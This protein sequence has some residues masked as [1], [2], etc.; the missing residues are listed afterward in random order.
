MG[1]ARSS[2]TYIAVFPNTYH[3]HKIVVKQLLK[4]T[5]LHL[6]NGR[7]CVSN[8]TINDISMKHHS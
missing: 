5:V 7:L 4:K 6:A 3:H 1:N 2:G 8:H